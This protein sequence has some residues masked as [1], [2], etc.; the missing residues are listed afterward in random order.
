MTRFFFLLAAIAAI[1][2][3]IDSPLVNASGTV[4]RLEDPSVMDIVL[5]STGNFL[6]AAYTNENAILEISTA[7]MQE[8]RR[9]GLPHPH[10]IE[11]SPDEQYLYS[12]TDSDGDGGLARIRLS[13]GHIDSIAITGY[14]ADFLIH[15]SGNTIW[16]THR[17]WPEWGIGYVD[18]YPPDD[19]GILSTIQCNGPMSISDFAIIDSIPNS[20]YYSES[21]GKLYIKHG[22]EEWDYDEP[23]GWGDPPDYISHLIT[24][25]DADDLTLLGETKGGMDYFD[26]FRYS[27]LTAWDQSGHFMM[28]PASCDPVPMYSFRVID[29]SDD[30]VDFDYSLAAYNGIPAFLEYVHH[31]G[32]TDILWA[33]VT[34]GQLHEND[35]REL[36]VRINR[37]TLEYDFFPI[38]EATDDLGD[39]AISPDGTTFYLTVTHTGEIIV[40]QP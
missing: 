16:V 36:M 14:I 26:Y 30:T 38:D 9:F 28:V 35:E 29:T 4:Y 6:Y 18:Y 21:Y 37:S 5:D 12:A 20:I 8:I 11:L 25:Y 1:I 15:P 34:R 23:P 13:D 3:A 2:S 32:D 17:T 33:N 39:F 10:R 40:W 19:D 31:I 24:I 27:E 22:L 7:N